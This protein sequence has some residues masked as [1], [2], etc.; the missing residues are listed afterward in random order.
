MEG[1]PLRQGDE[2]GHPPPINTA[3][4]VNDQKQ[5]Q[6]WHHEEELDLVD[7]ALEHRFV[8]HVPWE[9]NEQEQR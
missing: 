9:A 3:Q 2:E 8:A 1:L 5:D 4:P 7:Q 6:W